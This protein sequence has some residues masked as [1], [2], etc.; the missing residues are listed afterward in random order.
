MGDFGKYD[1]ESDVGVEEAGPEA[2]PHPFKT[3]E[4]TTTKNNCLM[5]LFI[6]ICH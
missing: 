5:V 6:V 4:S 2:G 3:N 1:Y